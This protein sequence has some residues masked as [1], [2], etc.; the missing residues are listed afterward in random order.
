VEDHGK[1]ISEEDL[2]HIFE[3]FYRHKSA[4]SVTGTGLGLAIVKEI[5]QR[6]AIEIEVESTPQTHTVFTFVFHLMEVNP[7]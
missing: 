4:D 3:R 2:E 5:A 7:Q 6:H 1:G